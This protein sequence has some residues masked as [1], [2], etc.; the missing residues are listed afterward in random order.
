[1]ILIA[2][3]RAIAKLAI[4]FRAGEIINALNQKQETNF[5]AYNRTHFNIDVDSIV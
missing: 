3:Y 4:G 1:V 5:A 2:I